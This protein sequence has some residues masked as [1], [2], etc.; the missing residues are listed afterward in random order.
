MSILFLSSGS[1][2][3]FAQS[4]KRKTL[5]AADVLQALEDMDFGEFVEPLK[6]SL[7]GLL[8]LSCSAVNTIS[9]GFK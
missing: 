3:N 6:E 1:A 5:L 7:D 4:H 9:Q 2:N 8:E